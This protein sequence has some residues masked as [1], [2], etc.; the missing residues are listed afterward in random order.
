MPDRIRQRARESVKCG[1]RRRGRADRSWAGSASLGGTGRRVPGGRRDTPATADSAGGVMTDS[2][3][4]LNS[5]RLMRDG[6]CSHQSRCPGGQAPDRIAAGQSP[7][8]Q[9]WNLLCDAVVLSDDGGQLLRDGWAVF[10]AA[11]CTT[12]A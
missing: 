6:V 11:A 2:T 5:V 7:R 3:M 9:G 12:P 1:Q 8:E 10:P 4:L